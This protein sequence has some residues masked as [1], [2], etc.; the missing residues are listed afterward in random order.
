MLLVAV[1]LFLAPPRRGLCVALQLLREE[2]RIVV[3]VAVRWHSGAFALLAHRAV[4]LQ[5]ARL[6]TGG[7]LKHT[8]YLYNGG[9]G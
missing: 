8:M 9:S 6:A 3:T 4:V 7:K 1:T 5:L 2:S